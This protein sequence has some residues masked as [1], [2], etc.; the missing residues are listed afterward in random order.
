[1][2]PAHRLRLMAFGLFTWSSGMFA[3][4]DPG[5][6]EV[7]LGCSPVMAGLGAG[8]FVASL[9]PGRVARFS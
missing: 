7:V 4:S 6:P 5:A 1:M 8:L 3:A 9:L 2:N